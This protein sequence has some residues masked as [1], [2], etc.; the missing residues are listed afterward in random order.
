MCLHDGF[1]FFDSFSQKVIPDYLYYFIVA[2]RQKLVHLGNGS[3]FVNLKKEILENYEIDLPSLG[4]QEKVVRHLSSID[5]KI[6]LCKKII[7]N[8]NSQAETLFLYYFD[9]FDSI[10]V[11]WKTKPLDSIANYLNGLAMQKFPPI[12]NEKSLPVL[13]IAELKKGYCDSDSDRCSLNIKPQYIINNGDVIFS[14]SA[15]LFVDFWCGGT[16]GLN[17]HLF[18]VTSD[19]YDKWFYYGWTKFYLDDFI[20]EATSKAT[21]M[22]HITRDRLSNAVVLVP[23]KDSYEKIGQVLAPL[24]DLIIEKKLEIFS[25]SKMRDS[26]VDVFFTKNEQELEAF[27]E[28]E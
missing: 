23:D 13:K 11:G 18:K 15:S 3:V 4:I 10:P 1:L 8:L 17:Q 21:T 20:R 22:G 16:A 25:L 27:F 14:W 9:K 7:E 19:E 2:N 6:V 24:Y 5:E 12:D 26:L 28:N